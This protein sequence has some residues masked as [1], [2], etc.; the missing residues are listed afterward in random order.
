MKQLYGSGLGNIWI[1]LEIEMPCVAGEGKTSEAEIKTL[2]KRK[3]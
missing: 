2:V 1:V 3:G